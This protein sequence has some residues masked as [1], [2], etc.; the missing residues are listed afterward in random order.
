ME[1]DS[2][3]SNFDIEKLNQIKNRKNIQSLYEKIEEIYFTNYK[4][5][6]NELLKTSI[7]ELIK[8]IDENLQLSNTLSKEEISFLYSVKSFALDKFPEYT[9]ESEDSASKSVKINLTIL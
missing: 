5:E 4:T 9:K 3:F 2:L 1:Y 6:R 8:I 7:L